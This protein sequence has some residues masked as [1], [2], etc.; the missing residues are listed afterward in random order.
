MEIRNIVSFLRVAELGNFTKAAKELGYSQ[1]AITV[2]ISQLEKELN[3]PLFERTGNKI[4]LTPTGQYMVQYANQMLQ[5]HEDMVNLTMNDPTLY[6][7]TLRLGAI[8]SVAS[9]VLIPAIVL[10]RKSY[11]YINIDLTVSYNKDLYEALSRNEA[12]LI[13]TIS[14]GDAPSYCQQ[15]MSREEPVFFF[16]SADHP[17]AGKGLLSPEDLFAFPFLLT[18]A[19][20]FLEREIYRLAD[21]CSRT[22]GSYIRTNTTDTILNL[23]KQGI[24]IS[25]LGESNLKSSLEDGSLVKLPVKGY[26]FSYKINAYRNRNKWMSVPIS[27]FLPILQNSWISSSGS[28]ENFHS[29]NI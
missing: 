2:H 26:S 7:G 14:N 5:I 22:I 27:G 17:L 4:I 23:V 3:A 24:G 18:G 6:K 16:A 19:D 12:D 25:F 15:L 11:P 29:N 13:F 9:T 21:T 8:E 20:S 10:F 1:A 28:M